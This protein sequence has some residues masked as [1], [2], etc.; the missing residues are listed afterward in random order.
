MS[1]QA[2]AHALP[3][4][5]MATARSEFDTRQRDRPPMPAM[6]PLSLYCRSDFEGP[7]KIAILAMLTAENLAGG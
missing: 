7:T 3:G 1:P 5:V 4:T 6:R 2:E